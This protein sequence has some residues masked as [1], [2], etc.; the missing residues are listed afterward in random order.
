M[1]SGILGET[2]NSLERHLCRDGAFNFV[3]HLI[4]LACDSTD[5]LLSHQLH[6]IDQTGYLASGIGSL[7]GEFANFIG[8]DRKS[9]TVLAGSNR[10]DRCIES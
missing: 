1:L 9:T 3:V 4:A 5:R 2:A 6:R 7:F 10:F 8:D